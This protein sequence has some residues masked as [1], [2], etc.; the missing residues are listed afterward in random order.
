MAINDWSSGGTNEDLGGS[1]G[2]IVGGT[3]GAWAAGTLPPRW[4]A[5]VRGPSPSS[6][7]SS[8]AESASGWAAASVACSTRR[9]S[10]LQAGGPGNF[11]LYG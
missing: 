9:R 10:P 5:L 8:A 7:I 1:A 6:E 3:V 2:A 4:P 11:R